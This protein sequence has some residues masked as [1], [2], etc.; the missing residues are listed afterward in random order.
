VLKLADD[1]CSLSTADWG[2]R[3]PDS[4]AMGMVM[5]SQSSK[6]TFQNKFIVI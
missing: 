4:T 2:A 3:A 5:S 6:G 1:L